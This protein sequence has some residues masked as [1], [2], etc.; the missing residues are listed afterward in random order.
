M[1]FSSVVN[2]SCPIHTWDL[3]CVLIPLLS[4][5]FCLKKKKKEEAAKAEKRIVALDTCQENPTLSP[6]RS[7]RYEAFIVCDRPVVPLPKA[8]CQE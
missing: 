2:T 8:L 6:P 3:F 4:F 1:E 5:P 7:P